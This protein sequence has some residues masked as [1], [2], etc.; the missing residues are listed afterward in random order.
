MINQ[1]VKGNDVIRQTITNEKWNKNGS[2]EFIF[3][4]F[5]HHESWSLNA[6]NQ[7]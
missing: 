6:Y 7:I 4:K 1:N 3:Y 5:S 2:I